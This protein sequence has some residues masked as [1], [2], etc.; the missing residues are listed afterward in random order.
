MFREKYN[1]T[2]YT[3]FASGFKAIYEIE[4]MTFLVLPK[5]PMD[6]LERPLVIRESVKMAAVSIMRTGDKKLVEAVFNP[7]TTKVVENI[8]PL[9]SINLP[10]YN[11]HIHLHIT[12]LTENKT[13]AFHINADIEME[14]FCAFLY[15]KLTEDRSSLLGL[16]ENAEV[17]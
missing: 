14:E 11:I 17:K 4:D 12:R 1:V 5:I 7:E 16:I 6:H 10:Y 15:E 2:A 9:I 13:L 3:G 8:C